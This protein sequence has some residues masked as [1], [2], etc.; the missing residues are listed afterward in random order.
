MTAAATRPNHHLVGHHDQADGLLQGE[1]FP[2]HVRRQQRRCLGHRPGLGAEQKMRSQVDDQHP[3]E[4]RFGDEPLHLRAPGARRGAPIHPTNIIAGHV[5][6]DA[7]EVHALR[8]APS[9]THAGGI[10]FAGRQ[11]TAD[12]ARLGRHQFAERQFSRI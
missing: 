8:A 11:A 3:G 1:G 4:V 7:V 2:R 6:A 9:R 10:A 5:R 12:M